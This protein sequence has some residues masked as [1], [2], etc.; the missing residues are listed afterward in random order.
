LRIIQNIHIYEWK[1]LDK[2]KYEIIEL[3]NFEELRQTYI[4]KKD[5][6]I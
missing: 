2:T 6:A 5:L 3:D 4:I 1:I